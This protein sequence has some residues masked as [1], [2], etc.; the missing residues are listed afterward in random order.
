MGANAHFSVE[1]TLLWQPHHNMLGDCVD[2]LGASAVHNP[3]GF[4]RLL[5]GCL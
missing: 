2:F 5:R 4:H 1:Q 3:V